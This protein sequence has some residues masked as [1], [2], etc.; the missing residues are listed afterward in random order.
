MSRYICHVFARTLILGRPHAVVMLVPLT[1][2]GLT[3]TWHAGRMG[4]GHH[5]HMKQGLGEDSRT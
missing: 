2:E 5:A 4:P 3:G 1:S